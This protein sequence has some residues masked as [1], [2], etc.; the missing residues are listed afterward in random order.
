MR[1]GS[2]KEALQWYRNSRS[3]P[4]PLVRSFRGNKTLVA[5]MRLS[6]DNISPDDKAAC[7]RN[8]KILACT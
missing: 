6:G 1:I 2:V 5:F 3:E 7:I 8:P 4:A